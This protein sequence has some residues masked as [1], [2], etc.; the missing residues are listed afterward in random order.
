MQVGTI[1]TGFTGLPG[2]AVVEDFAFVQDDSRDFVVLGS[3]TDNFIVIA[4]MKD[5]SVKKLEL[6]P[7]ADSTAG[8]NRFVEWAVDTNFVWLSGGDAKELYVVELP[9][10]NIQDAHLHKTI[11]NIIAGEILFVDNFE[12]KAI[13]AQMSS[14]LIS[15]N[16]LI[17]GQNSDVFVM[18][19]LVIG[20]VALLLSAVALFK[21]LSIVP[22]ASDALT[23][24]KPGENAS[25]AYG[26]DARTLGSK[27]VA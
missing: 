26:A 15:Q 21:V 13:A 18:A 7:A 8:S 11:P 17:R 27:M 24:A 2:T 3:T 9:S 20:V 22:S 25:V 1:D 19:A 5:F 6:S 14:D 23:V 10:T 12:R 16:S 4:D